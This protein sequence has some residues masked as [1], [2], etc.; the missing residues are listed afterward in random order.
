MIQDPFLGVIG[1]SADG[2]L[3]ANID[4]ELYEE[5]DS[6]REEREDRKS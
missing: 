4:L 3:S 6:T 1:I 5:F 2:K